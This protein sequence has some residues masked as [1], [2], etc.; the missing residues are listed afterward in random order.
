MVY[1]GFSSMATEHSPLIFCLCEEP[2]V[3][4]RMQQHILKHPQSLPETWKLRQE[5]RKLILWNVIRESSQVVTVLEYHLIG[6]NLRSEKVV[7]RHHTNVK[8]IFDQSTSFHYCS[9]YTCIDETL[10]EL[11]S[12]IISMAA[13]QRDPWSTCISLLSRSRA[14]AFF[15]STPIPHCHQKSK[16]SFFS[17]LLRT[18]QNLWRG[19]YWRLANR[20][21]KNHS[22]GIFFL[23]VSWITANI[24]YFMSAEASKCLHDDSITLAL[25]ILPWRKFWWHFPF[26]NPLSHFHH[27]IHR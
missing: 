26:P 8:S 11:C 3:S 7:K 18:T 10:P 9:V 25:L 24:N 2:D 14:F 1:Y 16:D 23:T 12:L 21:E 17:K 15:W 20:R 4:N 22:V 19:I 5:I 27:H 6:R 13:V